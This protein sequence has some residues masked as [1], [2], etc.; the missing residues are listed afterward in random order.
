MLELIKQP[1][2]WAVAGTLIGLI[3]PTLLLIGNKKL[4]VSSSMRHLCAICIPKNIPFF[5]YDWKKEIW[6][7][8]FVVGILLGG[9]I[10]AQFLTNPNE[11]VITETTK[12]ILAEYGI[13]DFSQ[14]MPIQIF[15]VENIFTLRGFF[16]F[17][18]GGFLVGFGSR[19]AGGCT[20]GHS[21]M[22]LATF[23]LPSLIATC[24]FMIG[25][26]FTANVILPIIFKFI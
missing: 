15:S 2:H 17:V 24:C 21:I 3:V 6:N 10:A 11:I 19:Y 23:Q 12:E 22:G 25:G 9:F 14:S 18:V 13:T 16:F 5:K 26:F 7:L 20:S 1:W 8:F 4:G